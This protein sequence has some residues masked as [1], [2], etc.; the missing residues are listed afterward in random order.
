MPTR[1]DPRSP[2]SADSQESLSGLLERHLPVQAVVLDADGR[3]LTASSLLERAARARGIEC[4]VGRSWRDAFPEDLARGADLERRMERAVDAGLQVVLPRVDVDLEGRQTSFMITVVPLDHPK[5]RVA[6]YVEDVTDLVTSAARERDE[7]A[8]SALAGLASTLAHEIRNPLAGM[9]GTL[10]VLLRGL[11]RGDPQEQV[12][13][14]FLS[15]IGRL[16]AVVEALI[17]FSRPLHPAMAR[18]DL[19]DACL[20]ALSSV[21]EAGPGATTVEGDG[22]AWADRDL[23][24]RAVEHLVRNAWQSGARRVRVAIADGRVVVEDD[25]PGVAAPDR[26]RIFQPFYTTRLHGLGLGLPE[27]RRAVESM[28]GSLECGS[29][30]LGGAAF[31]IRL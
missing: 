5:A 24:A 26:G 7:E 11:K 29:S 27:A 30:A 6:V 22:R 18:L 12:F 15:H 19:R 17:A 1:P 20:R 21:D 4:I 28:D 13:R 25:G 14:H 2:A 16:G 10:Q 8:L 9:S 3:V 23:L 31:E